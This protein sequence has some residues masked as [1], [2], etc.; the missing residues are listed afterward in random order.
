MAD[1]GS[2]FQVCPPEQFSFSSPSDWPRWKRR[3]ER[4]RIASGLVNKTEVEQVNSLIY[5]MG[6]QA[7]DILL[8][9]GL[10][11]DDQKKFDTVLA[12]F[13]AHFIVKRN[14]IYERSRFN[15]RVQENGESVDEFI[16]SL[17]SLS[18][19][20]EYGQLKD[21]LIRD[22]IVVGVCDRHLA[23]KM[24]L[25]ESLTLEKAVKMSRQ[26]ETVKRQQRD[27]RGE[28]TTTNL[29][30]V[31]AQPVKEKPN[32]QAKSEKSSSSDSSKS[33]KFCGRTHEMKKELCPAWGKDC[34][35]CGKK[36][37][38]SKLC[39]SK[40]GTVKVNYV[41]GEVRDREGSFV[42]SIRTIGF[43]ETA[44]SRDS[45]WSS[46]V[47]VDNAEILF[48][49]DPGADVTVIPHTLFCQKWKS[50]RLDHPTR[51]VN[52]PDGSSLNSVG[53]FMCDLSHGKLKV[54][55]TVYVIRGLQ[56]P[57]LGLRAC[58]DLNLVR[59]VDRVWNEE[60]PKSAEN[61]AHF[62]KEFPMLFSGLG[63]IDHPYTIKLKPDAVPYAIHCPR[64]VPL[65]LMDKL[66]GKIEE[67][68]RDDIIE[69]VDEPTEWCAPVVMAPKSNGD[70][71]CVDLTKLNRNVEREFHMMPVVEHTL[72]QISGAKYFTKRNPTRLVPISVDKEDLN[73]KEE[74]R[75]SRQK[76]DYDSHHRVQP[77]EDLQPEE[78]V[79]VKDLRTWG[80]VLE[81]ANAPGSLIVDTPRGKFRRNSLALTRAHT[82]DLPETPA[83]DLDCPSQSFVDGQNTK[84]PPEQNQD[85]RPRDQASKNDG[86]YVTRSGRIV[87]PVQRLLCE[88]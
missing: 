45:R 24:Q 86:N 63:K 67:F 32:S 77:K 37:H 39:K 52:G 78:V 87:K 74:L 72:G 21:E 88:K 53:S 85:R 56:R 40:V 36:N 47:K 41:D 10:S 84:D 8:S 70:R 20:C 25:D 82:N 81:N 50:R 65:P 11:S 44:Q 15:S 35:T 46:L 48:K 28:T 23:E 51:S 49:L 22:R 80:K 30:R 5:F 43:L 62:E 34:K 83:P 69:S 73:S 29:A 33:C 64:R 1:K 57:L 31:G 58:E 54:N 75:R 7:D 59:R 61:P 9:F 6:D 66:K 3:F 38:F 55:E 17:Y 13:E 18:E 26:H 2:V 71:V 19:Y 14:T 4:F 16:T 79:W 68:L 60:V 76:K 42:G 27:L 12:K